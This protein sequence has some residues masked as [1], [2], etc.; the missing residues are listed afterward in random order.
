MWRKQ[1]EF[2]S[3]HAPRPEPGNAPETTEATDATA[4]V[5]GDTGATGTSPEALEQLIVE[6]LKTVFDPEIPVNIYELG[7]IYDVSVA[8]DGKASIRMTLTTPMCPA[9]EELPPEVETKA[10]GVPG[11]TSVELELVWEPP[12]APEMMS[13]AARLDLG[14]V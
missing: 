14:M 9:A 12:W 8:D 4:P 11:V 2:A 13:E 10:R 5:T 3:A 1:S 7:L 6:Q